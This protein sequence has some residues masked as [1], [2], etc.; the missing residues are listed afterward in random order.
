[1][2]KIYSERLLQVYTQA[3]LKFPKLDT[4]AQQR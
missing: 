4:Q 3:V 1:M 2:E